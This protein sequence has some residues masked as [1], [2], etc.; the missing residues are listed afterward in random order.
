MRP[1][2]RETLCRSV[3]SLST[4]GRRTAEDHQRRPRVP[5]RRNLKGIPTAPLA[6]FVVSDRSALR[7]ILPDRATPT[8]RTGPKSGMTNLRCFLPLAPTEPRA[9][10]LLP[11]ETGGVEGGAFRQSSQICGRRL[12]PG[13]ASHCVWTWA[14]R[15]AAAFSATSTAYDT[16]E[17]GAAVARCAREGTI[18]D[19]TAA[20]VAEHEAEQ[21]HGPEIS[22]NA[23][24]VSGR[25]S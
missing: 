1:H 8:T 11:K 6:A 7:A 18:M 10:V 5:G 13:L 23:S 16:G 21:G 19:M 22:A 24:S 2:I 4:Y 20:G 12:Q 25:S 15:L 17:E 14:R 9:M 3:Q